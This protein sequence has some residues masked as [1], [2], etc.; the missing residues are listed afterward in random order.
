MS[1]TYDSE[2]VATVR[3]GEPW[4]T[5]ECRRLVEQVRA[6]K[7]V[8]ELAAKFGRTDT[9][10]R[11]RCHMLLPLQRRAEHNS[12]RLAVELLGLEL[13]DNPGYDWEQQLRD[14]AA[15]AGKLYWSEAMDQALL[16]GWQRGAS[17]DELVTATGATEREMAQRLKR[18]GLVASQQE[19]LDRI[20]PIGYT[21]N[22]QNPTDLDDIPLWVLVVAGLRSQ[23]PHVSLHTRRSG[24]ERTL[25]GVVTQHLADGGSTVDL[26]ITIVPRTPTTR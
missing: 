16:E 10:I 25:N 12:K 14:H 8:M 9:A 11:A 1:E 23:P 4:L 7:Q 5:A 13:H 21:R 20:G 17:W 2:R 18:R 6:G 19:I 3:A 22:D 26:S 15:A 24:A